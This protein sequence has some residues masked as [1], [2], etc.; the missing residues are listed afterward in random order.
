MDIDQ[1]N[2]GQRSCDYSLVDV[3]ERCFFIRVPIVCSPV[4][5]KFMLVNET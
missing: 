5:V 1:L 2:N 4:V 3:A